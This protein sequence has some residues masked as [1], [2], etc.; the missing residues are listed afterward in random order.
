MFRNS[1]QNF[2][3]MH[4]AKTSWHGFTLV[5]LITIL[6]IISMLSAIAFPI[7]NSYATRAK[8]TEGISIVQTVK[9]ETL[10]FEINQ[11]R[12][13]TTAELADIIGAEAL[14][15]TYVEAVT[16]ADDGTITA[17]FRANVPV[18]GYLIFVPVFNGGALNWT[19]TA[20]AIAERF[21]PV[22]CRE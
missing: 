15:G 22:T 21:L 3:A 17:S 10:L 14:Q 11:G 13:P 4:E 18:G 9:R 20:P 2:E 5:E 7:Y 19:C 16:I 1:R 6:F 12:F 8:I